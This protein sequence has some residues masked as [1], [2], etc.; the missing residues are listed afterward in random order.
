MCIRDRYLS[1]PL[2][3]ANE[4]QIE[5]IWSP[6]TRPSQN[7]KLTKLLLVIPKLS[8]VAQ[9]KSS[10]CDMIGDGIIPDHVTL[11]HVKNS[12]VDL[13]LADTLSIKHV[14][15]KEFQLYAFETL[16]TAPSNTETNNGDS[17]SP[18]SLG[19]TRLPDT[20]S[21]SP[22]ELDSVPSTEAQN[23]VSYTH[24]TLPTKA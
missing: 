20:D 1:V 2:P 9:I 11:A 23:A 3:H 7:R 12:T 15:D 19:Y 8:N 18:S 5:I 17:N 13:T 4:R 16:T 21:N 6:V 14:K 22:M 24:L 10:L